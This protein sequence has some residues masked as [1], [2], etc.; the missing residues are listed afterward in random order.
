[1]VSHYKL[2]NKL[3]KLKIDVLDSFESQDSL[4]ELLWGNI[5]TPE[6]MDWLSWF[7]YEK[8]A[9]SGKLRKDLNAW[10][11]S[12]E[13]CKDVKSLYEY[14]LKSNYFITIK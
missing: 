9:I 8:D 4:I 3:Y 1:M 7:L 12:K 10:D 6:G 2:K 11:G 13:I 5:L 14:L